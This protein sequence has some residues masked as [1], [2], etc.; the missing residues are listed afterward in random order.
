MSSPP[1]N[2][3]I[4]NTQRILKSVLVGLN[5]SIVS[6]LVVTIGEVLLYSVVTY[7]AFLLAHYAYFLLSGLYFLLSG[8]YLF[9]GDS[10]SIQFIKGV[11]FGNKQRY[12]HHDPYESYLNGVKYLV[13]ALMMFLAIVIHFKIVGL[14]IL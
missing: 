13:A 2:N 11:L 4:S 1:T 3:S 10:F 6:V 8:F 12:L 5:I 7:Q 14:I 9:F